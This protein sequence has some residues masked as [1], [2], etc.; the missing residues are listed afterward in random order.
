[1]GSHRTVKNRSPSDL[2]PPVPRPPLVHPCTNRQPHWLACCSSKSSQ[3]S[4]TSG[5]WHKLVPL[6]S[7]LC[8]RPHTCHGLFFEIHDLALIVSL[9]KGLLSAK[10]IGRLPLLL[11]RTSLYSSPSQ[12][13]SRLTYIYLLSFPVS[14]TRLL[15][16]PGHAWPRVGAHFSWRDYC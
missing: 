9:P 10:Y 5:P 8:P 13:C 16:V 12:N 2:S 4:S 3:L 1:M 7:M 6:P 11:C 14:S 15:N